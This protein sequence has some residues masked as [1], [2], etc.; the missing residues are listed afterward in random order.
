MIFI[1]LRD[2][3][4]VNRAAPPSPGAAAVVRRA[5]AAA[6]PHLRPSRRRRA[7]AHSNAT[8][9]PSDVFA[10]DFDG[11]LV[12]SEP[13][14]SSAA[15]EA[16][17]T[18]DDEWREA[19]LPSSRRSASDPPS[20]RAA[21]LAALKRTR[22]VLVRGYEA[23]VMARLLAEGLDDGGGGGGVDAAVARILADW[24]RELDAAMRR[25]GFGGGSGGDSGGDSSDSVSHDNNNRAPLEQHFERRRR[26]ALAS[27]PEAWFALNAP[28]RSRGD[29]LRKAV[30]DDEAAGPV[31]FVSSKK[32][33]RVAA[34]LARHFP[35][36]RHGV[37]A[38]GGGG[39]PEASSFSS[40][41]PRL[42]CSLLPP[43]AEKKRALREILRRP[44]A[45]SAARLH[46]VDDRLDT[47]LAVAEDEELASRYTL[48]LASW[49]YCSSDEVEQ[50]RREQRAG[51][52][53]ILR[54]P[55]DLVE[56]LRWG[57]FSGG[58]DDGCEP[59]EEEK[60]QD[61]WLGRG[62]GDVMNV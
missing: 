61:G 55:D 58:V 3:Q 37:E 22:P 51:R 5:R 29:A 32:A 26:D 11:V 13:E 27:S 42:F 18:Y 50:A 30:G 60:R 36:V 46:F 7:S 49:G 19:V 33:E 40:S 9:G 1:R 14:V 2:P 23:V 21:L 62:G 8:A 28:Y 35:A 57:L 38:E 53:K 47:L 43:E 15:L 45:S 20:R 54:G 44:A 41:S 31:Y 25:F 10:L 17:I 16:A 48:Y 12:D 6:S 59:T 39:T 56:L 52:V 24:P 4:M 34:L